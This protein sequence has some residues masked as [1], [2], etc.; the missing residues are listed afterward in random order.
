MLGCY[1]VQLIRMNTKSIFLAFKPAQNINRL[2]RGR[3]ERKKDKWT[4]LEIHRIS[5]KY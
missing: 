3:K 2:F 1:V 5:Y 4:T